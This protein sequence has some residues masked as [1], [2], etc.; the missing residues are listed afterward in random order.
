MF[1]V[2]AIV[3]FGA[4][5]RSMYLESIPKGRVIICK[6]TTNPSGILVV[7]GNRENGSVIK[8]NT[9]QQ[10]FL[11]EPI[12]FDANP[13][14]GLLGV[15]AE[16]VVKV[17]VAKNKVVFTDTTNKRNKASSSVF[18]DKHN[19][20]SMV[21]QMAMIDKQKDFVFSLP[22]NDWNKL[23]IVSGFAAPKEKISLHCVRIHVS[24]KNATLM[25]VDGFMMGW[26]WVSNVVTGQSEPFMVHPKTVDFQAYEGVVCYKSDN[27]VFFEH[28]KEIRVSTIV[29]GSFPAQQISN[30]LSD[31]NI[32]W[33]FVANSD[34][35]AERISAVARVEYGSDQPSQLRIRT[36]GKTITVESIES[37]AE[38]NVALTMDN[39]I[40]SDFSFVLAT[41]YADKALSY[42]KVATDSSQ[43]IM[44]GESGDA[45]VVFATSN[46]PGRFG[47]AKIH[48]PDTSNNTN[49]VED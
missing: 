42:I 41:K 49:T 26:M 25:A 2:K 38:Q 17:E 46:L 47:F 13:I 9:E 12:C 30:A 31:K 10:V 8:A 28:G 39:E 37:L 44:I 33:H 5:K 27:R 32:K 36:N 48:D 14:I 24:D 15:L 11:D 34:K 29:S 23:K 6:D 7:T 3:L 40:E 21:D 43:N 35:L 1:L 18:A 20:A 19:I 45:I 16:T 4:I 22:A